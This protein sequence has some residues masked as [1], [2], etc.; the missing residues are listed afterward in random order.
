MSASP[1]RIFTQASYSAQAPSISTCDSMIGGNGADRVHR[2]DERERPA[3]QV[4]R[5]A[6]A[7]EADVVLGQPGGRQHLARRSAR[8]SPRR[9]WCPSPW[10]THGDWA[11]PTTAT[12]RHGDRPL[13]GGGRRTRTAR[14]ARRS[15]RKWSM[16][17]DRR[18]PLLARLPDR[19]T[20]MPIRTSPGSQP[21]I[22]C[23]NGMSAP[24]SSDRRR[25]VRRRHPLAG[26]RHVD[27]AERGHGAGVGQLHLLGGRHAVGRAG[28][29]RRDVD[30]AAGRAALAEQPALGQPEQV[31]RSPR[32]RRCAR[33]AAAP[34]WSPWS[35]AR[36][37][38]AVRGG[39]GR[40]RIARPRLEAGD[41]ADVPD[42]AGRPPRP[43]PHAGRAWRRPTRRPRRAASRCPRRPAGSAPSANGCASGCP[44]S[45]SATQVQVSDRPLGPD[46]DQLG[47]RVAGHRVVLERRGVHPAVGAA[48]AE[49]APPASA[50]MN[51]LS[52]GPSDRV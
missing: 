52:V 17:S 19:L 35:P 44:S 16:F 39:P 18:A 43:H 24:S 9:W 48:R 10:R 7:P 41:V 14:P 51:W 26:E 6:R 29:A 15:G 8:A 32:A 34:A 21:R 23:W 45:G 11:K 3:G 12:S 4:V 36:G 46:L 13:T 38:L 37:P 5:R 28:A 30:L 49:D 20:R 2:L 40:R 47:R 22:R 50:V 27:H 31:A 42:R 1:V 25:D 33:S